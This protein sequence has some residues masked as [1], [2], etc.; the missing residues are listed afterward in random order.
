MKILVYNNLKNKM[1]KYDRRLNDPMPYS[2]NK[3]LSVKEFR[4]SSKTD[5]LWTDRRAIEAFNKLRKLYGNSI[6]V[7]YAFK[8]IGEGGHT[9]QSQHYAGMAFD[10]AQGMPSTERD[11]IRDLAIKNKMFTYVEPKSLTPTWV[12]VDKRDVLPACATGGYP[13]VKL[14]KKGVYVA[15]LQDALNTL[16]YNTGT[17]DGIFGRNTK[18]AVIKYQKAKKLTPDGIVG[19]D[20]W[21]SITSQIANAR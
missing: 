13:L 19:C 17:I 20:T 14:G 12:H 21:R 9:G 7:G 16:G 2:S 11:K 8:R 3:Y 6:K 4:G 5:V 10:I 1:E 18:N 15:V